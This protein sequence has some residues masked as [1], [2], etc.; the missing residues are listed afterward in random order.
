MVDLIE[1]HGRPVL[2]V[3]DSDEDFDSVREA[4]L[5]IGIRNPLVRAVDADDA[6][7]QLA[8]GAAGAFSF[9]LLDYNL[10]GRDGLALLRHVR[11]DPVLA[12]LPVVVF[13][14]SVNPRDRDVFYAAGANAY[15]VK[16]VR[17]DVC[18]Q[19]LEAIFEYWLN[20][21]ALPGRIRACP[22]AG[23]SD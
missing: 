11:G 21:V 22:P 4:A 7:R 23:D 15:H 16:S 14:T 19:T 1:Q 18:L 13:T 3:E 5:R 17:Y 6:L 8:R 10:P 12:A 9:M 20:R 2:V